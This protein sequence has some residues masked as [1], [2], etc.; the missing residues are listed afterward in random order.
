MQGLIASPCTPAPGGTG[1]RGRARGTQ[2]GVA[3]KLW[4][5]VSKISPLFCGKIFEIFCHGLPAGGG[6][7]FRTSTIFL[8][9][10][11]PTFRRTPVNDSRHCVKFCCR[12]K[13][14][15]SMLCTGYQAW[16]LQGLIA[17]PCTLA[18]GGTGWRGRSRGAQV[19]GLEKCGKMFRKSPRFSAERFSKSFATVCPRG[20]DNCFVPQ[21]FSSP[22][23]P[24]LSADSG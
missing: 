23:D 14:N 19:G 15:S 10:L 24:H 11:T 16:L 13:S 3:Q 20:D 21:Q 5:N 8:P 9:L 22:L 12:H 18:P 17:S 1:W 6:Q 4:Q 7:L 2:V